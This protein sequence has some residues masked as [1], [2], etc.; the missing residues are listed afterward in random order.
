MMQ[1]RKV[2]LEYH[3]TNVWSLF[4]FDLSLRSAWPAGPR[5]FKA[6]LQTPTPRS[7]KK[8]GFLHSHWTSLDIGTGSY[9]LAGL[10]LATSWNSGSTSQRV[11]CKKCEYVVPLIFHESWSILKYLKAIKYLKDSS[12]SYGRSLSA[13][14]SSPSAHPL[15]ESAHELLGSPW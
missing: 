8:K 7:A 15:M 5:C 13:T 4:P 3:Q 10:L 6:D 14:V 9:Q 1:W 2:T 11:I 12:S